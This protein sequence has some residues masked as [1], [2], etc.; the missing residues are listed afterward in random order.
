VFFALAFVV[1]RTGVV[2]SAV[3]VGVGG[4]VVLVVV[5]VVIVVGGGGL[6]VLGFVFAVALLA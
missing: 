3:V 6:A 1:A 5:G 2:D 4:L